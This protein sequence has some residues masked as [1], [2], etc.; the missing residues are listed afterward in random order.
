MDS[1]E[2]EFTIDRN[3]IDD[4]NLKNACINEYKHLFYINIKKILQFAEFII[5]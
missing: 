2:T 3:N 1:Y 4:P 5:I